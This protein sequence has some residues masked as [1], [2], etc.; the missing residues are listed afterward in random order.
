MVAEVDD[1]VVAAHPEDGDAAGRSEAVGVDVLAAEGEDRL[2]D[3]ARRRSRA[4]AE[5]RRRP[6]RVAPGPGG[7]AS[8]TSITSATSVNASVRRP[9]SG[10][11]GEGIECR[12][13]SPRR[14]GARRCVRCRPYSSAQPRLAELP[15]ETTDSARPAAASTSVDELGQL[16][17]L[18]LVG[19]DAVLAG[20]VGADAGQGQSGQA[21]DV[22]E[23]A[24][25][26]RPASTPSRR[27]PSS[28][29]S[30]TRVRRAPAAPRPGTRASSTDGSRCSGWSTR[31]ARRRRPG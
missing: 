25:R 14:G 13:G 6:G 28:T 11:P 1:E 10:E 5:C 24:A 9:A 26:G 3:R 18:G 31:D 12:A 30:T 21:G 22:D 7:L 29:M 19:H 27:S 16:V 15:P 17:H 23:P 2:A 8:A 4:P 20:Q